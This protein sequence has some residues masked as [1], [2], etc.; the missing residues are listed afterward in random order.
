MFQTK[1]V[2]KIKTHILCSVTFF[3]ENGAVYEIMWKKYCRAGQATDD[4]MVACWI[5]KATSTHSEY[6]MFIANLLQHWLRERDS[7][8]RST[9]TA[10]LCYALY[11]RD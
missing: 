2:E 5:P 8:L 6:V 1:V 3:F 7:M 4:N 9:Y 11:K 10:S